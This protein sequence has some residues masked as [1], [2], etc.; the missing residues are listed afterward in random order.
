MVCPH[1]TFSQPRGEIQSFAQA[2]PPGRINA[3]EY[4]KSVLDA[5][6]GAA[7]RSENMKLA[8][9]KTPRAGSSRIARPI[10]LAAALSIALA[11][12]SCSS[13][14][15]PAAAPPAKATASPSAPP[16]NAPPPNAPVLSAPTLADTAPRDYPGIHNAV[17]F[18]DGYISGGVPEGD[19]GFASL[20]AMGI[21]T[22]I[23]VDGAV[24]DIAR[25]KAQGLRYIHLPIGYNGFDEERKLQLVRAT[26]DAL[27]E[28]PVYIHCHHGKH[29]SAGAAATVT[30][31][32]G[33]SKP[34]EGVAR[35]RVSGTAPTY[36]GLYRCA[37][38][39]TPLDAST[40]DAVSSDFPSVW[41]PTS[42]VQAMVDM[43]VVMEHL[44]AIEKAGWKAPA[45]HPDLVPAAEAGRLVDLHRVLLD[46]AYVK[47]KPEDFAALMRAGQDRAQALEDA[48]AAGFTD[49]ALLD[50]HFKALKASCKDCHVSYRD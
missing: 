23:S 6:H 9:S 35:M 43:D 36:T 15:Q 31:S 8:H 44:A 25:A 7:V 42:F 41:K 4:Q 28:G 11:A 24:P 10:S 14:G 3:D 38:D 33:W 18:H 13:T 16:P 26:R 2:R 48:L 1:E 37:A 19:A 12:L 46:G 5:G 49:R 40:I 17:A 29:R 47:R 32:L 45:D 30:T 21:R 50:G 20:A 27:A 39:A 22:I 34:E